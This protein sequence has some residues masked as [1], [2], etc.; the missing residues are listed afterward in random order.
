MDPKWKLTN[1]AHRIEF[2]HLYEAC[3]LEDK[4]ILWCRKMW[5]SAYANGND[6][7]M[8]YNWCTEAILMWY[9]WAL[10]LASR[11]LSDKNVIEIV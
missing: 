7:W 6:T 11:M 4:H 2:F 8:E 9:G 3:G 1:D 5:S 10:A